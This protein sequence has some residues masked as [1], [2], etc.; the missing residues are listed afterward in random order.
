MLL[1]SAVADLPQD[2]LSLTDQLLQSLGWPR[3]YLHVQP[4]HYHVDAAFFLL[5]SLSFQQRVQCVQE[6][7]EG[8]VER[9]HQHAGQQAE[10]ESLSLALPKLQR[11][12]SE[13]HPEQQFEHYRNVLVETVSTSKRSRAE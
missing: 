6:R 7:V 8:R 10:L 5:F 13:L 1:F 4:A 2:A 3:L 9:Q 12:G 11:D